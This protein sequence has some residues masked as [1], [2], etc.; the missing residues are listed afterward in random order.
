[1]QRSAVPP[2]IPLN[3]NRLQSKPL[4]GAHSSPTFW[5]VEEEQRTVALNSGTRQR[6][7]AW[8]P[9]ILDLRYVPSSG[10][11]MRRRFSPLMDFL[12]ISFA[13]G[14]ILPWQRW[15]R[16]MGTHLVCF[17]W[18]SLQMEQLWPLPLLM[19]PW[20]S[21][22]A[23]VTDPPLDLL[24]ANL[25]QRLRPGWA[26]LCSVLSIFVN[27]SLMHHC[28]FWRCLSVFFASH[29]VL[30]QVH[31]CVI[32]IALSQVCLTFCQPIMVFLNTTNPNHVVN[33]CRSN[34]LSLAACLVCV[35]M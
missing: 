5:Q 24:R 14:S 13:F 35:M 27:H 26:P 32:W 23:L 8:T 12:R 7:Y 29:H 10:I 22:N 20:D 18:H 33:L 15:Q 31:Y 17:I 25:L 9:L 2:P 11:V 1:M 16:W 34:V 3:T 4:L 21:G 19:K 28:I 6:V 30:L